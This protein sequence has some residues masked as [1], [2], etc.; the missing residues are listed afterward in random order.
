MRLELGDFI[1]DD[2]AFERKLGQREQRN[3]VTLENGARYEGEW[4]LGT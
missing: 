4:L 1:Y 2:T 3:M